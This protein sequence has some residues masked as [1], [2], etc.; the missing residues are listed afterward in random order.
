MGGT[1]IAC[2]K[3]NINRT[4]DGI[5]RPMCL[6]YLG[7]LSASQ[8]C[9]VA[10][11]LG[12][13]QRRDLKCTSVRREAGREK[14]SSYGPLCS[15]YRY[16][17]MASGVPKTQPCCPHLFGPSFRY[18]YGVHSM[19]MGRRWDEDDDDVKMQKMNNAH[20]QANTHAYA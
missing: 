10:F 1:S 19:G 18:I 15:S 20:F 2:S 6:Q 8:S 3:R 17:N 16:G 11:R 4:Y 12:I 9:L 5:C 13:K 7:F 14:R